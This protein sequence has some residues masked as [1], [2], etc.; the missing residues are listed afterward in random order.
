MLLGI[1][2]ALART[3]RIDHM[4]KDAGDESDDVIHIYIWRPF[5]LERGIVLLSRREPL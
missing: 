4:L 5:F 1:M 2:N 3:L